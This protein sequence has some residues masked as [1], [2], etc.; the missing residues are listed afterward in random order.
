MFVL[1]SI[2]VH[3]LPCHPFRKSTIQQRFARGGRAVAG[4][5]ARA[6][7]FQSYDW[8]VPGDG[9]G[10]RLKLRVLIVSD[11]RARSASCR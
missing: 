5:N 6:S 3:S 4:S 10:S 11:D 9:G 1:E 8:F 2:R 7:F